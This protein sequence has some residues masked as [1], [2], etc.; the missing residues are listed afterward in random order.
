MPRTT[1]PLAS[2]GRVLGLPRST[3]YYQDGEA[4]S[5]DTDSYG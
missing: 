5:A 3:L 4:W 2:I 1:Y